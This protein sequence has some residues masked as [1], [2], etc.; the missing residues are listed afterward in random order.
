MRLQLTGLIP[1][2]VYTIW[3]F[4]FGEISPPPTLGSGARNIG[5][6]SLGAPDGSQSVVMASTT[7]ERT[8]D[9]HLSKKGRVLQ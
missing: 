1:N 8:I 6:G 5:A 4:A 9:V 7:G 3:L 2:G